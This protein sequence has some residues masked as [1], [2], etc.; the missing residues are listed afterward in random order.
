MST[1]TIEKEQEDM[2]FQNIGE[3]QPQIPVVYSSLLDKLRANAGIIP[4]L[5]V[6]DTDEKKLE[7]NEDEQVSK[8]KPRGFKAQQGS[9][10]SRT[11]GFVNKK[12][13]QE[14]TKSEQVQT[15]D[16]NQNQ[17]QDQNQNQQKKEEFVRLS[18]QE[19][20]E[21]LKNCQKTFYSYLVEYLKEEISV[22][23]SELESGPE[24]KNKKESVKYTK[25][26][27]LVRIQSGSVN[28]IKV[29][30]EKQQNDDLKYLRDLVS[31]RSIDFV[32]HLSLYMEKLGL[33][34]TFRNKDTIWIHSP[35][36]II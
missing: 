5:S 7:P 32:S 21:A 11:N 28:I 22:K 16:Q 1:I 14:S 36:M 33:V 25:K 15:Q 6:L 9:Y 24:S 18:P 2:N 3:V 31:N 20:K 34:T 35:Y 23:V 12:P 26:T 19:Y 13:V 8:P 4:K 27:N 30:K 10:K 29:I 17:T